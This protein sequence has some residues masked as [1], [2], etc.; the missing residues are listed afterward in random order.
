MKRFVM[1]TAAALVCFAIAAQGDAQVIG[2]YRPSVVTYYPTSTSVAPA[3]YQT[4]ITTAGYYAPTVPAAPVRTVAATRVISHSPVIGGG[5]APPLP[6]TPVAGTS[7]YPVTNSACAAPASGAVV[8]A[9]Y[10]G[11]ALGG[12]HYIG[13]NLFGRPKIYAKRQPLRNVLRFL[14]P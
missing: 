3:S 7:Y 4:P 1:V 6:A 11:T 10:D 13:R 2:T 12:R 8:A 9:G 5:C 14:G